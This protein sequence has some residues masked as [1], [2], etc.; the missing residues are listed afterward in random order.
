MFIMFHSLNSLVSFNCI[1]F[2]CYE[3]QCRSILH[4][5]MLLV[6]HWRNSRI[7]LVLHIV[8]QVPKWWIHGFQWSPLVFDWSSLFSYELP[9]F[10]LYLHVILT[11]FHVI[12]FTMHVLCFPY[13]KS[14][15]S[16]VLLLFHTTNQWFH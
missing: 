6:F 5:T 16:L 4:T 10:S 2:I 9:V 3:F 12:N 13:D 14:M 7:S 15:I 8:I 11:F 1:C